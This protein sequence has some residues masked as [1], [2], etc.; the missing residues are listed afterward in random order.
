MGKTRGRQSRDVFPGS[1]GKVSGLE[2]NTSKDVPTASGAHASTLTTRHC[3]RE[4]GSRESSRSQAFQAGST[5]FC[6]AC[7]ANATTRSTR[8]N[9]ERNPEQKGEHM[10]SES[11][12]TDLQAKKLPLEV[13]RKNIFEV[14]VDALEFGTG[15][16]AGEMSRQCC[17][18]GWSRNPGF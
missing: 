9:H 16:G 3:L 18:G 6:R 5:Q 11:L 10:D 14:F 4:C 12:H 13:D 7:L 8:S 1:C 15:W 2:A 17:E